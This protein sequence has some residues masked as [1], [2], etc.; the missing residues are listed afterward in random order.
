MAVSLRDLHGG[1]GGGTGD[2]EV[3]AGES[4]AST[5]RRGGLRGAG[6]TGV[7]TIRVNGAESRLKR[8]L[9]GAPLGC[10]RR[11]EA[12]VLSGDERPHLIGTLGRLTA[13]L[14]AS[15]TATLFSVSCSLLAVH[16]GQPAQ[17]VT[18]IAAF[19]RPADR[20]VAASSAPLR[21]TS[22]KAKSSATATRYA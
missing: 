9:R 17:L 22:S 5:N 8:R 12:Q 14:I 18:P 2:T 19:E 4:G 13:P 10:E 16:H 15:A 21:S 7:R 3:G 6:S 11:R 20:Y 1:M